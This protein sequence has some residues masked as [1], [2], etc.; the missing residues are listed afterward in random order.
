VKAVVITNPTYYG[1]C[2]DV[3]AIADRVHEKG[4]LLIVDEAH[5][6]HFKFSDGLPGNAVDGGADL[7]VQSA[8]KTLP[9][10]TQG[11][12]L[13][14]KGDRVD[15]ERLERMLGMLQTTSPSYIIMASLDN[16]RYMMEREG[17]RR[18][19]EVLEYAARARL[20]ING[21]GKGF[22]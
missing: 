4:A 18:L 8:H 17:A 6:A 15:R 2:S 1:I 5:G 19:G 3:K 20:E 13:H 11:S 10:M 7:V 14:V 9:A 12:W 21:M 16:A 22:F